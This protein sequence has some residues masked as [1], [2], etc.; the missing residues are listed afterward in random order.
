MTTQRRDDVGSWSRT[1]GRDGVP[2]GARIVL[3]VDDID[4]AVA[5]LRARGAI[6]MLAEQMIR[7]RRPA[8]TAPSLS[9]GSR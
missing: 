6:V 1:R 4:A 9:D 5:R 8:P 3:A 2:R 7:G